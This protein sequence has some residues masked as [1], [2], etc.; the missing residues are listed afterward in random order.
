MKTYI[1]HYNKLIDRKKHMDYQLKLNQLRYEYVSNYGKDKLTMED[2]NKFRNISDSEISVCLHHIECFRKIARGDDDY[3]LIF[4]DDVILCN[5]FKK[6]L[7]EY[8]VYLPAN[9]DMLFIGD[10]CGLHIPKNRLNGD[11]FIYL[12]DNFPTINGGLGATRC[13]DSYLITKKCA[14]KIVEKIA[15]PN[16]TIL[17]PADHWLNCVIRNNNFIV[18]WSEPTIV[19]Q[20]SEK[21]VFTSSIR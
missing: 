21:N 13:L 16:Y 8:L 2:K 10:G 11:N 20:G 3:A 12:K 14:Q 4:E 18:Y 15:Q 9:W 1:V 17:C 19:T 7:E 5:N 6:K